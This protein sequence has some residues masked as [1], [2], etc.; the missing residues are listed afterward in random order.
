MAPPRLLC[1]VLSVLQVRGQPEVPVPG[2]PRKDWSS[3]LEG[4]ETFT[5][6]DGSASMP[7]ARLNDDYCDCADGSDEP[8]TSACP[9][10]QY[11]CINKGFQGKYVR[12]GLVN[13]HVCD[14]CDGSDEY[15]SGA[16]CGNT[17]E[18]AGRIAREKAAEKARVVAAGAA[19]ARQWSEKALMSK[20][21]WEVELEKV[22][23]EL[24]AKREEVTK[25]EEEKKAAEEVEERLREEHRKK[26]AEKAAE[27]ERKKA[28]EEERKRAEAEAR[29]EV[30]PPPEESPPAEDPADSK[31]E[32]D[33]SKGRCPTKEEVD[34]T[35]LEERWS[36]W[37]DPGCGAGCYDPM[38]GDTRPHCW[39]RSQSPALDTG[40]E[41]AA[42]SMDADAPDA[43]L[44]QPPGDEG[45]DEEVL[46]QEGLPDGEEAPPY[47]EGDDIP[48]PDGGDDEP[49]A[50]YE[51][52]DEYK[53][54]DYEDD[55]QPPEEESFKPD[56]EGLD[57]PAPAEAEPTDPE[58][59]RLRGV[60]RSLQGEVTELERKERDFEKDIG[61]DYGPNMAFEALRHQCADFTPE[62]APFT[63]E[64]C[65]FKD[66][67][68][69]PTSV[70]VGSWV[71]F[72]EGGYTEMRFE[73]GTPCWNGPSRS[74][75]VSVECGEENKI[76]SVDE[77][78][79]CKYTMRF[80]TPAACTEAHVEAAAQEVAA[81][82]SEE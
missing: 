76:I 39:K 7:L 45:A 13:D 22:K 37:D 27:E 11:W 9:N 82:T 53:A 50:D 73:N 79:V 33:K 46:G 21:T 57:T 64:M 30:Y 66:A 65:P 16:G 32:E 70:S 49:P 52:G 44:T 8:G 59:E 6:R 31:G 75:T 25:V 41:E 5:C 35:P 24:I 36:T 3:Y 62:G 51:G 1:V 29:G 2:V 80:T 43:E 20:K 40:A 71:G 10:G 58:A 12:S 61:A 74:L 77:P 17:C 14:C 68:Q 38:P 72:G 18:E 60:H 81:F 23:Q 54:P 42:S 56:D 34:A 55:Y 28:E 15:S 69:K 67:R 63:Y 47:G 78:E 4:G 19:Q 26:V 48:P